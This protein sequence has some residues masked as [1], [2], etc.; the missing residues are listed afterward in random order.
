MNRLLPTILCATLFAVHVPDALSQ[1]VP[2]S[3]TS[4]DNTVALWLF[5]ETE[6]PFTSLLDAGS[7]G[8]DLRLMDNGRLVPGRFG[9]ALGVKSG[10]GMNVCYAS[11]PG[12]VVFEHMREG[13]GVPSGL[14]GPTVVP[15]KLLETLTDKAF[16]VECWIS[17][18]KAATEASLLSVGYGD[19]PGF[20]MSMTEGFG[21]VIE[22][23]Y[24]G[25]R[26]VCPPPG[27][28]IGDGWHHIA[29]TRSTDGAVKYY[30]DGTAA[31]DPVMEVME[32]VPVPPVILPEDLN[33]SNF[34]FD[35]SETMEWRRLHRFNLY[36]G[37]DRYG[38]K[39][40]NGIVDEFRISS[41]VR[42]EGDFQPPESFSE[43]YGSHAPEPA[44]QTGRVPLAA[45]Q[46]DGVPFNIGMRK[47][48]FID[49]MLLDTTEGLVFACNR[50]TALQKLDFEPL[51][52]SWS[53]SVVDVDGN[54]YLYVPDGYGPSGGITRLLV[55]EDG[56][57]FREPS[58]GI[59]EYGGSTGNNIVF[60][61]TPFC[62]TFFSDLNPNVPP[63]ERYKLTAWVPNRGICLYHSPD[64]IDWR[65]N[66]TLLL[67]LASGCGA[68]TFYDDQRGKYLTCIDLKSTWRTEHNPGNG[69]CAVMGETDEI[70]K[71]WPF[72]QLDDP[73][74]EGWP[75]PVTTGELPVVFEA[76]Q[77]GEVLSTRAIKY[78]WAPDVYLAFVWRYGKDGNGRTDLG[79][80]RDGTNWK[81]FAD[82]TWYHDLGSIGG[83][84]PRE[85]VSIYGIIR[86]GDEL[87]QYVDYGAG[88]QGEGRRV[89][90]R[91]TQRLDG[92]VSLDT[93]R[94]IGTALTKPFIFDG[95]R[96]VLNYAT[97]DGYIKCALL[98]ED[99]GM[100]PGYALYDCEEMT[101]ESTGQVVSWHGHQD[102]GSLAGRKV[103]LK[104]TMKW[105][106]L[107]SFQFLKQ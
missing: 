93:E 61:G 88:V 62:G 97:E 36:I 49:D 101:G 51:P 46:T 24:A 45:I 42:Y 33:H 2:V 34:D 82:G 84:R 89:Y 57:H 9:N 60:Q 15:E 106:K 37:H 20:S 12:S 65:R 54:V 30:V 11:W 86:R 48:L 13:D 78:P 43:N 58:L 64:G 98:D 23:A 66:E 74:F 25:W 102:V 52:G 3:G 104:I 31:S 28:G 26:A 50:P 63:D 99:G 55:S 29:L 8:F 44:V 70:K 6:Y 40:M 10:F 92:F 38:N 56:V 7:C 19:D 18:T 94:R 80:S 4:Y 81:F 83:I 69:R 72:T 39:D 95:N 87:W 47:H 22:N 32:T 14:L 17:C 16:T 27:E 75:F 67:P 21:A 79:V 103:R 71:A 105:A 73:Y 85:A 77:N 68:E 96:L 100:I 59:H 90:A 5:D 107:Y 1:D 41:T 76:D 91:V 35:R 53:P